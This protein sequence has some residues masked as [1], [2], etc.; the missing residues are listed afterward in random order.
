MTHFFWSVPTWPLCLECS[1]S[2]FSPTVPRWAIY[3]I[4]AA[5]GLLILICCLCICIKCCCRKKKKQQK[6]DDKVKLME[7]NGKSSA[8]LVSNSTLC[9]WALH[10]RRH[11]VCK[12]PFYRSLVTIFLSVVPPHP[13]NIHFNNSFKHFVL[14][15]HLIVMSQ[16]TWFK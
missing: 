3:T 8:A 7:L 14:H 1:K 2:S 16:L 15:F 5:G 4:F 6:K 10:E 9:I 13:A 12:T 11:T